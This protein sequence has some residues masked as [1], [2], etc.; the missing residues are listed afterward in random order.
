MTRIPAR[1]TNVRTDWAPVPL[2]ERIRRVLR[3]PACVPANHYR[4]EC[5]RHVPAGWRPA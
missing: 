3:R 4:V 1:P 2:R 5:N